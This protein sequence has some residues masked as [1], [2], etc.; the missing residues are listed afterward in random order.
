[1]S[2]N[3]SEDASYYRGRR[4]KAQP[5]HLWTQQL[6]TDVPNGYSISDNYTLSSEV[7]DSMDIDLPVSGLNHSSEWEDT[8]LTQYHGQTSMVPS[9]NSFLS[10][11]N[12]NST[13]NMVSEPVSNGWTDLHKRSYSEAS[14]RISDTHSDDFLSSVHGSSQGVPEG[15]DPDADY[16]VETVEDVMYMTHSQG[17]MLPDMST[18]G[19]FSSLI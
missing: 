8:N 3:S 16:A 5:Q 14:N 2:G 7:F 12:T 10:V 17:A 1:M 19:K 13:M 6:H 11:R 9:T 18:P 4:P 15:W